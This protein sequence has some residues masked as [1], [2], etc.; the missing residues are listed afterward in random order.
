MDRIETP[1]RTALGDFLMVCYESDADGEPDFALLH[2]DVEGRA[3]VPVRVQSE[4]LTGHVFA[5]LSCDCYEQLRDSLSYIRE[6]DGVLIYLRQE[7]RGIGLVGKL[8]SYILQR[9][10]LDTVDANTALGFGVDDRSYLAAANILSDLRIGSVQLLTNNPRKVDDL[11]SHGVRVD[12]VIQVPPTVR[13][14]NRYYLHTK[15]AR[16]GHTFS[17]DDDD[18]A[19]ADR[20]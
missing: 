1:L 14:E 11:S 18:E 9:D 17:L 8:R 20:Q 5:S 10:G 2:G 3:G 6:H 7:G 15:Q 16:L 4:C 12:R 13:E 19:V